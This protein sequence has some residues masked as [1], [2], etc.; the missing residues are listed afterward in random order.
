METDSTSIEENKTIKKYVAQDKNTGITYSVEVEILSPYYWSKNDTTFFKARANAFKSFG[1]S[2]IS[3]TYNKGAVKNADILIKLHAA[4]LYK[5]IKLFLNGDTLYTLYSYQT[6][7]I[8]KNDYFQ[9]FFGKATFVNPYPSTIFQSKSAVLLKALQTKDSSTLEELKANFYDADFSKEDLP[10]LYTALTKKYMDEEGTY[11]NISNEIADKIINLEDSTV[12]DFV[13]HQ[14]SIK[15]DTTADVQMQLLN[16]LANYKTKASYQLLQDLLLHKTPVKGSVY[17]IMYHFS[18]SAELIHNFFPQASKLYGDT[19][20]GAGIIRVANKL[21]DSNK[22]SIEDIQQ[23]EKGV[24]SLA[25]W[26]LKQLRTDDEV[27]PDYNEDVINMLG[28][29]NTKEGNTLL[30]Q[31][32]R[33]SNMEIKN[34]AVIALLK[35]NQPVAPADVK[36]FAA[37]KEWRVSF[38]RNLKK[39]NKQSLFPKEFYT[40]Q[41]FAESH[42]HIWLSDDDEIAIKSMQLVTSKTA[43]I[44]GSVKRFYIYKVI[45]DEEEDNTP[46]L[47]IC[48]PFDNNLAIADIKD[49]DLDVYCDYES[50][51]SQSTIDKK[52]KDY[53]EEKIKKTK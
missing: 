35:N 51:F 46:R 9:N 13:A 19:I 52:F 28:R 16:L 49:A 36:K 21:L 6:E 33:Q 53:I 37:D 40:Q 8:M 48:G 14:Y 22:V 41:K 24:Y 38:Y 45:F 17:E 44:G 4:D 12:I 42:L 26:Q 1:D 3:Y 25:T 43:T 10:L 7:E 47:A 50:A 29:F 32:A 34:D 20:V 5:R 31:F 39:I 11:R 15:S 30:N 18:D 23:N 2:L 27:Y